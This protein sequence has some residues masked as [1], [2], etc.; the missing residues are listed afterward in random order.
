MITRTLIHAFIVVE[1]F[2][3]IVSMHG[4]VEDVIGVQGNVI[5]RIYQ[6]VKNGTVENE[7]EKKMG[8]EGEHH[9]RCPFLLLILFN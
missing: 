5:Y 9:V 2:P 4:I 7:R 6:T 8:G 3:K 1:N